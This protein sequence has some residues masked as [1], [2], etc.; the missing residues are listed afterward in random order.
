MVHTGRITSCS[1]AG[2]D[3]AGL[4]R[5]HYSAFQQ[6]G[7]EEDAV[8]QAGS[9]FCRVRRWRDATYPQ[10]HLPSQML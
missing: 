3:A 2:S 4:F 5:A 10:P 1:N 8:V 7:S 6:A 9:C